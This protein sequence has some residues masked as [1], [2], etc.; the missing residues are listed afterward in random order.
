VEEIRVVRSLIQEAL[1]AYQRGQTA[2]AEELKEW[3]ERVQ[4]ADFCSDRKEWA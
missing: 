3:L 2:R 4:P 1:T